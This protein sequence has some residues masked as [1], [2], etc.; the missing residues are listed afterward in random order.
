M[1]LHCHSESLRVCLLVA[2]AVAAQY[3]RGKSTLFR[4][5]V[6][7]TEFPVAHNPHKNT[8]VVLS[9]VCFV[10]SAMF[11]CRLTGRAQGMWCAM[12][13]EANALAAGEH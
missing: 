5:A 7:E 8:V 9:L 13:Q 3:M 11:V 4:A 12:N 10:L 2:C 1:R 6:A